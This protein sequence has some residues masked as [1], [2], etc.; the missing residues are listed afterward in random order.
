MH[1]LAAEQS[2]AVQGFAAGAINLFSISFPSEKLQVGFMLQRSALHLYSHRI[3]QDGCV[4]SHTVVPRL[5]VQEP[6]SAAPWQEWV[7][8]P[9]AVTT[10]RATLLLT[11]MNHE[12]TA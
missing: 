10:R 5:L 2:Q 9:F 12:M 6:H 1:Q 11:H 3:G 4:T 7:E 8:N